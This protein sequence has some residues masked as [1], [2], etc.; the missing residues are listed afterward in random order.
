MTSSVTN[1]VSSAAMQAPA[2]GVKSSAPTQQDLPEGPTDR[3]IENA[4]PSSRMQPL[5]R[6]DPASLA[7]LRGVLADL[8]ETLTTHGRL[9]A[10]AYA[11]LARLHAAGLLVVVVTGRS[12]GWC[13]HIA[14]TWPVDA[15]VA[16]NGGLYFLR[17]GHRVA[18]RYVEPEPVRRKSGERLREALAAVLAAVPGAQ[19]A[20][21][22]AYRETDLALDW[23][24]EVP[25]LSEDAVEKILEIL[26]TA[27]ARTTR[28]NIHVHGAFGDHDKLSTTALAL[29]EGF[30]IEL[31]GAAEDFV[32]VGDS[33]NDAPMFR[34]FTRTSVGVANAAAFVDRLAPPPAFVTPS[35]RG[36]GFV[37]LADHLLD[38]RRRQAKRGP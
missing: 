31:A 19:A 22:Q 1:D 30:G 18:K 13:D 2:A 27:G 38:A 10:G 34:F 8:D 14:R 16:E 29:R 23:C 6:F 33:P 12:A 20:A 28:S 21:D 3:S 35:A 26:R 24:E 4:P 25:R 11:A 5:S 17:R 36:A 15:V 9:T 7:A 37:E 32:F